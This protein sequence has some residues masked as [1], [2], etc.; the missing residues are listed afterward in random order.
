MVLPGKRWQTTKR[1]AA[2]TGRCQTH[3]Q[4]W[5]KSECMMPAIPVTVTTA[6]VTNSTIQITD[7]SLF[8][9]FAGSVPNSDIVHSELGDDIDAFKAKAFKIYKKYILY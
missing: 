6:T 2:I 5:P 1:Q 9:S 3:Q 8:I 4:R 7:P